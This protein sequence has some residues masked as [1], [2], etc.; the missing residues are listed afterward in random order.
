MASNYVVTDH[1][2]LDDIFMSKVSGSSG[3]TGYSVSGAGDLEGRYQPKS[4]YGGDNIGFNTNYKVGSTDLRDIFM[5]KH[6]CFTYPL[7]YG[8]GGS[9]SATW[10]TCYGGSDNYNWDTGDP[11]QEGTF[12]ANTS[13][14]WEGTVSSNGSIGSGSPC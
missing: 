3:T 9:V 12:A 13:C 10:V 11:G 1:G 4:A 2:D 7:N 14:A 6:S 5:K 8:P